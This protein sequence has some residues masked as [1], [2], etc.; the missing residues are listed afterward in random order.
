M[1]GFM[2]VIVTV[3]GTASNAASFLVIPVITNDSPASGPVGTS[4]VVTGTSFGDT[5]GDSTVTFNGVPASPTSW[6]NT[7][8]TVPA[9]GG[10]TTGGVVVTVNGFSTNGATFQVLPN[11]TSLG[12]TAG[13]VGSSVT[14]S[15]TTFGPTQGFGGVTFNGVSA[16]VQSW[17]DSS[18]TVLVPVGATS[19]NIVV[20]DHQLLT[21]NG[22]NFNVISQPAPAI[23][24][25]SPNAG[26][27][28]ISATVSGT[29]F[30]A[31]Q[32]GSS[33]TFNGL[34]AS[35]TSWSDSSIGAIV[36]VG[37]HT[38]AVIVTTPGGP[39]NGV[40]FTFAPGIRSQ[41][42]T[43]YITPDEISLEAGGSGSF[44]VVDA[45]GNPVLDATW[46]VDSAALGTIAADDPTLPTATLEALA[47]GEITITATSSLG[48][49]QA[50]ATI[51]DAGLMPDGTASWGFYPE[52][53]DNFFDFK[54]RSR[55]N[56]ESDPLL[57]IPESTND[58]THL[59]ALSEN[60]QLMWRATLQPL[61]PSNTFS[62]PVGA[63]GTAD[64]GVL[65]ASLEA[66]GINDPF[67][68]FHRFGADRTPRWTYRTAGQTTSEPAI[69]PDG[70]VFFRS[71]DINSNLIAIDDN[72]GNEK[73]RFDP[74]GGSWSFTSSEQPGTTNPDGTPV[75]PDNPW[76][77]CADFF[78]SGKF[79]PPLPAPT[80]SVSF[81][82]VIG[83]DGSAYLMT[84][85]VFASFNYDHCQI[86]KVGTD[87]VTND[88]IYVI[89]SMS[90]QLQSTDSVQLVRVSTSGGSATTQVG[91]VSYSG[92]AGFGSDGTRNWIFN[93]GTSQLPLVFFDKVVPDADG[94]A[95]MTWSQQSSTLGALPQRSLTKVLDGAP[96]ATFSIT[97]DGQMA[98]NDQGIVF[99]YQK[100]NFSPIGDSV[101]ALDI[102]SGGIPKWTIAGTLLA[103]TDD[104]GALIQL[105]NFSIVYADANGN[106]SP[107][108]MA[109]MGTA[110]FM[111]VGA[112]QVEGLGGSV[113]AVPTNQTTLRQL[114]A[115][116]WPVPTFGNPQ[117]ARKAKG[118]KTSEL[119]ETG[120]TSGCTGYD[121]NTVDVAAVM[122][123]ADGTNPSTGQLVT[124]TGNTFNFKAPKNKDIK[125]TPVDV[126]ALT[127]SLDD[128][129]HP[130]QLTVN[131][132]GDGRFH[133]VTLL[134]HGTAI[135]TVK[136][137]M[138]DPADPLSV[139]NGAAFQ[140]IVLPYR[141]WQIHKF[142]IGDA[143]RN[144]SP[145]DTPTATQVQNELNRIFLRQ[146]NIEFGVLDR[147][148]VDSF[149]YDT[150]RDSK[151]HFAS[152][153]TCNNYELGPLHNYILQTVDGG[154]GPL[155]SQGWT[156]YLYYF[157]DFDSASTEGFA[158]LGKQHRSD[159][160]VLRTT[161]PNLQ[162]NVTQFI[163]NLTSHEIGH[164]LGLDH[165]KFID[166]FRLMNS[167]NPGNAINKAQNTPCKLATQEWQDANRQ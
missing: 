115:V 80:S 45:S 10:A 149:D 34:P 1:P 35:V 92:Q 62:F 139:N 117:R 29:N 94:G 21:S 158:E 12:P 128:P 98:T 44:K 2:D 56:T 40:Q 135:S 6:S 27:Q 20:T 119:V 123:P 99:F 108:V 87:P 19:G 145:G 16:T 124:A 153:W 57:Y 134:G 100:G 141:F 53:Q 155:I 50:K 41:A 31:L 69:G 25:I 64:G 112:F 136:V 46:T 105:A 30:G 156:M 160:A 144:I 148:L 70:T 101:T 150:D 103:A 132:P 71:D 110:S 37:V 143:A 63:A 107:D 73:F 60:G 86:A 88:P 28:G 84:T 23:S 15:G 26:N 142:S 162:I 8:L 42:Q 18:I 125:L 165:P 47:P 49:A 61:D 152:C 106:L 13:L 140:A 93:N 121:D 97:A 66:G 122:A 38:G 85:T 102:A 89:T 159:P 151:L 3:G 127:L 43:L 39:S 147:G 82:P 164:K 65:I 116:P 157:N 22:L 138:S 36:P 68:A 9:P 32:N 58:F 114:T 137:L 113:T 51:F 78:P 111:S 17:S 59:N 130:T 33:I 96:L 161:F 109:A 52:T 75:R 11:I 129:L 154:A 163:S 7:S 4:V 79:N 104:G 131:V 90:G 118:E 77:P 126:N 5:Q 133:K 83:T 81:S 167:F 14:I 120:E 67:V 91:S 24:F 76:K 146:A 55:H 54:I 74:P 95:L 72:T 166:R 48:T